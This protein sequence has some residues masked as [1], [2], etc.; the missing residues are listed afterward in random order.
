MSSDLRVGGGLRKAL[1]SD[2]TKK[3]ALVAGL[4]VLA[5]AVVCI[6]NA[7]SSDDSDADGD[8]LAPNE[9]YVG[10]YYYD[11]DEHCFKIGLMDFSGGRYMHRDMGPN[12]IPGKN[13]AANNVDGEDVIAEYDAATGTL[14]ARD[15][16]DAVHTH[17]KDASLKIVALSDMYLS[18]TGPLK[19]LELTSIEQHNLR[20]TPDYYTLKFENLI[21]SGNLAVEVT[22]SNDL[23]ERS[24]FFEW[25]QHYY[26][27]AGTITVKDNASLN[28]LTDMVD[29][30]DDENTVY[31]LKS[32]LKTDHMIINTNGTITLGLE[33]YIEEINGTK[34]SNC[35]VTVNG[36]LEL[37]KCKEFLIYNA[38][39][40]DDDPDARF[41][42]DQAFMT[43]VK[44]NS[45]AGYTS[46]IGTIYVY[47]DP[48]RLL[49]VVKNVE[50]VDG[51]SI[52]VAEP[53]FNEEP[54]V[55]T[56][57]D[58]RFVISSYEWTPNTP[59]VVGQ[60]Y[61]LRVM[62]EPFNNKYS[63]EGMTSATIAGHPATVVQ[64]TDKFAILLYEFEN[65][66]APHLTATF[67][68]NNGGTGTMAV[69][70]LYGAYT[71]PACGF[72]AP[73]GMHFKAWAVG[74]PSGQQYL[75]GGTYDVQS[76]VSFFAIWEQN[77]FTLQPINQAGNTSDHK[78]IRSEWDVNFTATKYEIIEGSNPPIELDVKHYDM[79]SDE[80]ATRTLKVRAFYDSTNY[81]ESNEFV[82]SWA[83]AIYTVNYS[84]GTGQGSN[85]IYYV[86]YG[87]TIVLKNY[88]E[89]TVLPP[90]G[91]VFDY[92]SINSE[93]HDPGDA[94]V[95]NSD[96]NIVAI[97]KEKIPDH[98]TA[99]YAGGP[100]SAGTTMN[101]AQFS[102]RLY[103][104]DG[105]YDDLDK[106]MVGFYIG[107]TGIGN[108]D[109]Y[110]FET[111]G[112]VT[113]KVI[114]NDVE[115]YLD[116]NVVGYTVSFN[117]NGGTGMMPSLTNKYGSTTL[118]TTTSYI[119]PVGK[120]LSKW[121]LGSASGT[122]YDLGA[123]Y[124]VTGD[125]TFYAIWA[126]KTPES[127][128]AI[129]NTYARIGEPINPSAIDLVLRYTDGSSDKVGVYDATYWSDAQTQIQNIKGYELNNAGNNA[130]IVKYS[131]L[132]T[133]LGITVYDG[134]V[135]KYDRNGGS[136]AMYPEGCAKDSSFVLP[137]CTFTAPANKQFKC[138]SVAGTERAVGDSIVVISNITVTAIWKDVA[139][140][141][142]FTP[143]DVDGK[144]VYT[145]EIVEGTDTNVTEIFSAAK[146]NSGSVEMKVGTMEIS[147]DSNAVN[148]I[149]GKTV[150]LKAEVKTTDLDVEG[151]QAVIEVSLDGAKFDAGQAKVTVPFTGEI[152]SGKTPVVYYI[153]GNEK[154]KMDT[155]Y[156]DGKI[157]FTTNH[158]SKYAVMFDDAPSSSGGGFPIWIVIVIVVVVA[159]AGIGV[160]FFLKNKKA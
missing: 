32:A 81:I 101:T 118:P 79:S 10:Y 113:L 98:L 66:P 158:F 143:K 39:V 52:S 75:A 132:Q 54:G 142:E 107:T 17:N 15:S 136:G 26:V 131:G 122:Q 120:Y 49:R 6:I 119:P 4:L 33:R 127:L 148:A 116:V 31:G 13:L 27:E 22:G 67:N 37:T 44:N 114:R 20:F 133:T 144:K 123:S 18:G 121:A 1:Q 154:V 141:P 59:F 94:V 70:D 45:I 5:F 151:A 28:A 129:Y 95:I 61:T 42:D 139:A 109:E 21:I 56:E 137:E 12:H 25:E 91:F 29:H 55:P 77:A 156:E 60:N 36:G 93:R 78:D 157:V 115:G 86:V 87:D 53:A 64:A 34:L 110:T 152:P 159:A 160:F 126:D 134:L 145:N 46:S 146:I 41:I 112:K 30:L 50:P 125:V 65:V 105:T 135:V 40:Y 90:I 72:T 85:D 73:F 100:I 149:G 63:F 130:L 99:T 11:K 82:V 2:Y 96:T 153:N 111:V 16:F 89:T 108:I 24:I 104:D 69:N 76:N 68:A 14:Y 47:G 102:G 7:M 38:Y 83:L 140:E 103:Y 88:K 58:Q 124:D 92:W 117:A 71:L 147:F 48:C 150:S 97:W 35:L 57:E 74:N 43:K 155:V 106:N 128:T 9:L 80:V 84:P 138:W 8:P 62:V 19:T 3:I 23:W 51:I